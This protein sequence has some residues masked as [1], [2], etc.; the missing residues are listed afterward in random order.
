[1]P[2]ASITVNGVPGS[3]GALPINTVVNLDNQN[4]G[5]EVSYAWSI[6][7][8]PPGAAD[9]LSSTAVQ[10]PTFTPKKEGSYLLRLVVNQGLPTEQEARVICAVLQLKTLERIPAAGETTQLD[11]SDGWAA[12]MSAYLRRIDTLLG[13]P[14]IFVGVNASGGTL[15]RGDVL[16]AT[17]TVIIKSGLPGQEALPGFEKGLANS[18]TKVDEPLVVCEG[19]VTGSS[20]VPNLALMKVRFLGRFAAL[21]GGG[22]ATVGDP[23]Y[24]S[25]TGTMSLTQGTVRRQ[26]GSAMTAGSTFDVFFAGVGGA[27]ITPIDR[28]YVVYGNPSPLTNAFR[29]DGNNA[30]GVSGGVPYSIPAT[31]DTTVNLELA[32]NSSSGLS[33]QRWLTEGG[34]VL[35]QVLNDGT[36]ELDVGLDVAAGDAE[37]SGSG[38]KLLWN[39]AGYIT[40][41]ANTV[42]A[43]VGP[44]ASDSVEAFAIPGTRTQLKVQSDGGSS[45]LLRAG[46]T[47]ADVMTVGAVPLNLM[48]NSTARWQVTAA[49]VLS[50]QGGNKLISNVADPAS[51][52]DAVTRNYLQANYAPPILSFGAAAFPAANGDA[53]LDVGTA[54]STL[55]VGNAETFIRVPYA[56]KISN[57]YYNAG[58]AGANITYVVTVRKNGSDQTLTVTVNNATAQA[59]DTTHSFTCAAGDRI[60]VKVN[61]T[62]GVGQAEHLRVMVSMQ[63]TVI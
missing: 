26:V 13:D 46:T 5:G 51:A 43:V 42:T 35:A 40:G 20:S 34:T 3:N 36:L 48:T 10:N 14:G 55:T 41:A 38:Q 49:G 22:T 62:V 59:A 63:A 27:E 44:S 60:S 53:Y 16:R 47:V 1:M 30:T 54:L 6:L 33:I 11:S 7:D 21:T 9:N 25:D 52:Q 24:V 56:C 39:S 19:T 12:A 61:T 58:A 4:S 57:L 15:T 28:A 37:F 29:V 17:S 50:A 23:V 31:D 32:R 18:L 2:Q 45:V 8:Q